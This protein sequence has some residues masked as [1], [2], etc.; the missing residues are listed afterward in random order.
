MNNKIFHNVKQLRDHLTQRLGAITY[1][2]RGTKLIATSG[3]FDPL[4]VGHVRC[5]LSS[6]TDVEAACRNSGKSSSGASLLI[7]IVNGDEFLKRKKG[8][9]FMPLL[10]RME[11]I[12]GLSSVDFVVPWCDDTQTVTGALAELKPNYFTKGGDRTG[13]SNVPEFDLC[14]QIGCNILFNVGGKKIQSSSRLVSVA[15]QND[16]LK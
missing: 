6:K 5:I 12:A 3:G 11:I 8:F 10:E 16:P 1:G 7:V 2:Y 9:V 15:T 4:H 13:R 14:Q